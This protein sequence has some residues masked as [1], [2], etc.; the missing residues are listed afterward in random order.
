MAKKIYLYI[1]LGSLILIGSGCDRSLPRKVCVR[2]A[3]FE[4]EVADTPHTRQK[5]L[6]YRTTLEKN[7]GMLFIF[8]QSTPTGFWMKNTYIPLDMIWIDE[9]TYIVAVKQNALP[10]TQD[11]CPVMSPGQPARYVLEINSGLT[12]EYGIQIGDKVSFRY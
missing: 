6:M 10:C 1:I 4:V 7:H 3:C 2:S 12:A 8:S 5:G 11:P 9:S